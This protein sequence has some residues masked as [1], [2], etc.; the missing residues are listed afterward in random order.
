MIDKCSKSDRCNFDYIDLGAGTLPLKVDLSGD[1][2]FP[3]E[4]DSYYGKGAAEKAIQGPLQAE[5]IKIFFIKTS[6]KT[7][8]V[9]SGMK[10]SQQRCLLLSERSS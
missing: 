10:Y 8:S 9:S 5:I 1:E 3:D 4:Y 2:F 6:L 7:P